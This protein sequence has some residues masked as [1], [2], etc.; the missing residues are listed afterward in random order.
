MPMDEVIRA[1]ERMDGENMQ[2]LL[3]AVM[4]RYHQLFPTH[5]LIMLTLPE[6]APEERERQWQEDWEQLQKESLK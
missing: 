5:S 2:D 3:D 4:R 1:V 6:N